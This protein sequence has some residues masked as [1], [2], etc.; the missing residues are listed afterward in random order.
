[1]VIGTQ[2]NKKLD[3]DFQ[4]ET[5]SPR[6]ILQKVC[7]NKTDWRSGHQSNCFPA[8]EPDF[9]LICPPASPKDAIV[10]MIS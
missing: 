10:F 7:R 6:D 8:N 1:M 4:A 3:K 2:D 5:V 9:P